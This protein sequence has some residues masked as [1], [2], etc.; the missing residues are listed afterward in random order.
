MESVRLEVDKE[1]DDRPKEVANR[2]K[3]KM[4]PTWLEEKK[5]P[6]NRPE[7]K[8]ELEHWRRTRSQTT[9]L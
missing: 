2:P 3:E 6:D 4:E 1:P 7:E 8:M 5:E 9:K